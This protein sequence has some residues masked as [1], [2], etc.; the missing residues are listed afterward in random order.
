MKRSLTGVSEDDP[1][2]IEGERT[3]ISAAILAGTAAGLEF[4]PEQV[5]ERSLLD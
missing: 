4:R 3:I 1:E 2:R 5:T